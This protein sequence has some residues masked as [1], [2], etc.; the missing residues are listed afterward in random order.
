MEGPGRSAA[1]RGNGK[2]GGRESAGPGRMIPLR[3]AGVC[4][5]CGATIAAGTTA[6]HYPERKKV[7]CVECV[8]GS[9]PVPVSSVPA[10]GVAGRSAELRYQKLSQ[11]RT[12]R[13]EAETAR[14]AAWRRQIKADHPIWGRIATTFKPPPAAGPEPQHVTAWKTG[15]DGERIVG[16]RLDNWAASMGGRVLHDRRIRGGNANI[17]HIAINSAGV[18][19][20]DA[21]QHKGMVT[22]SGGGLF[23]QPELRV[24]GRRQTQLAEDVLKQMCLVADVLDAAAGGH[25]RPPIHG[26][27]CFV[28]ADW[29][30]MGGTFAIRGVTVAWPA[31][32]IKELTRSGRAD[33]VPW[34]DHYTSVL[35]DAF[36]PA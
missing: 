11:R 29:P 23:S 20:I 5:S 6:W 36:P 17:D 4:E 28:R 25:P 32:T 26:I 1:D 16:A 22:S 13:V 31:A 7:R 15:A 3:Y 8:G 18:W 10:P 12:E 9:A 2:A 30:L 21:K 27:L 24:G 19:V 14:D 33:S 35:A 34:L